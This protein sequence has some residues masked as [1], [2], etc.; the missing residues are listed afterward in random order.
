MQ[1][2]EAIKI[3]LKVSTIW[4]RQTT[5]DAVQAEWAECLS[6]VS[7]N[8]ALEAVRDFRDGGRQDAPTPGEVFREAAAIDKRAE[9]EKR[10]RTLKLADHRKPSEENR[11]RVHA[12]VHSLTERPKPSVSQDAAPAAQPRAIEAETERAQQIIVA[13]RQERQKL[14]VGGA[15]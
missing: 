14:G 3:L 12:L 5:D 8:A 7:F 2:S 11:A 13:K 15:A 4:T 6:R 10:R 1:A 9:D